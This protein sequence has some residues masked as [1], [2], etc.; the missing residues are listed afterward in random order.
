M[1]AMVDTTYTTKDTLKVRLGDGD[2]RGGGVVKN[3]PLT[4]RDRG[5]RVS[6]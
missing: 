2:I 1:A 4:I 3:I 6:G 5:I